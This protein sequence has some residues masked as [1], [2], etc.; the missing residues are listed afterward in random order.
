MNIISK[1]LTVVLI[2]FL[3]GQLGSADDNEN[4]L[5]AQFLSPLLPVEEKRRILEEILNQEDDIF[6]D[7][8]KRH[9]EAFN[10]SLVQLFLLIGSEDQ[11]DEA[12]LPF[13]LILIL[14]LRCL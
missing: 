1:I 4:R 12:V 3:I 11:E 8:A 5:K 7:L 14:G 13:Y 2:L 10:D 9:P 6:Q